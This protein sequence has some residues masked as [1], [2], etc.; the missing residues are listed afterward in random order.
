MTGTRT[1]HHANV[2]GSM[3][4]PHQ[5]VEAR[6]AVYAARAAAHEQ[7]GGDAVDEAA[8]SLREAEDRAVDEALGIQEDAGL[9]IVTD[10]EMRRVTFFDFFIS[11]MTGLS[12]IPGATVRFHGHNGEA[13]QV[14]V[15]FSVTDKVSAATCLGVVEFLYARSR[16]VREVK[17]CLP[18]PLLMMTNFWNEHSREAYPDPFDLA[19]DARDAV[20]EWMCELAAAGCTQIQIDTPELAAAHADALHRERTLAT[21]GIDPVRFLDFGTE[22][23]ASLGKVEL[24]GVTKTMH[25][26]KGNGTQSWLASGGYAAFAENVFA[27]ADG[28]DVYHLEHDDERSGDF[29]PLKQLPDDKVAVLGMVS[30]KWTALEAKDELKRRIDEAARFHPKEH[31]AIATQCGFASAAETA[32]DRKVTYQTQTDK[33]RLII[34]VASEVWR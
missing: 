29:E 1:I 32:E 14:V 33:L 21:K 3:L 16:T 25:V 11:G 18:S 10:G 24:P 17:V 4:R 28:F 13:M 7:A 5:L 2:V 27:R 20:A 9:G 30:T 23:I 19:V 8:A 26:C 15:P 6:R 12:M 34:E 22:L 31:L